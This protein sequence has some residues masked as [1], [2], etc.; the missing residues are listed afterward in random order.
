[1]AAWLLTAGSAIAAYDTAPE[2]P[3][4]PAN[5]VNSGPVSLAALKGKAAFLWFYDG[6]C[7]T[8]RKRWPELLSLS[9]KFEGKPIVFIAVN[10][11]NPRATV[12][13]YAQGVGCPWPI[14]V[15]SSR[16]YE[17]QALDGEI[18]LKN[19]F[20]ARIITADGRMQH[21]DWR[22]LEA[23]VNSGL[24]GARWKVEPD[25]VPESLKPAWLDI[26]FG[27]YPAAAALMKKS[28]GSKKLDVQ[29]GAEKL[30][31]VIQ[32]EIDAQ[33]AVARVSLDKN[34]KWQAWQLYMAIG[35]NFKGFDL[36]PGVQETKKMLANDPAVKKE[37][38]AY[39]TLDK[40]KKSASGARPGSRN[41]V[42]AALEKLTRDQQGTAAAAEAK[43][44]LARLNGAAASGSK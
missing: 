3:S 17:K 30:G 15:D 36:P 42:A 20:Q 26:E 10:S 41:Q 14:L 9:K 12:A 25:D 29:A 22:D 37:L 34:E 5:W 7:P 23:T 28:L 21:G 6:D 1:L 39:K 43:E 31:A 4:D 19:I 33:M 18:S 27:N 38:L 24:V 40:I 2:F 11:G 44:L 16:Q 13:K 8:C 35:Q 32:S